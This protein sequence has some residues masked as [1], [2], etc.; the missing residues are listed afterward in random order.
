M[1]ETKI[2]RGV[3][4]GGLFHFWDGNDFLVHFKNKEYALKRDDER[5]PILTQKLIDQN[6]VNDISELIE[7]HKNQ[8]KSE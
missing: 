5:F 8:I 4:Y 7:M 6:N 1:E 3:E 2:N